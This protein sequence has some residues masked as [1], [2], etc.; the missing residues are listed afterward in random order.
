MDNLRNSAGDIALS[1]NNEACY[2]LIRDAGI[3]SGV[4]TVRYAL[5][6]Q[7]SSSVELLLA[8]LSSK[9]VSSDSPLSLVLKATDFTAAGSTDTY[10]T[11]PLKYTKDKY[12]QEICVVKVDDEEEVGVMMGWERDISEYASISILNSLF[13][14]R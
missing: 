4:C 2:T 13:D 3:R 8:L 10:L 5:G 11:T 7:S 6:D 14:A 1:L 12:G 9:G